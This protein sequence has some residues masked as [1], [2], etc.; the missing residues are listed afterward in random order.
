MQQR[1]RRL[2]AG[3]LRDVV[4][5]RGPD[6][7]RGDPGRAGRRPGRRRRCRSGPRS[8]TARRRARRSGRGRT[9]YRSPA[10]GA[11]AACPRAARPSVTT[12]ST[13]SSCER[14]MQLG[15]VRPPAH[16][17]L[18]AA[19]DDDVPGLTGQAAH[20]DPGRGPGDEPLPVGVQPDVGPVDL[21]VVVVLGVQL[22][23]LLRAP[24]VLEVLHRAGGRLTC[25]VPAFERRDRV[26]DRRARGARRARSSRT[27]TRRRGVRAHN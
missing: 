16:A 22:S 3:R 23:D 4:G 13:P 14:A 12:S 5:D 19:D 26:R 1:Q 20:G 6:G 9:T 24:D 15:A 17:G 21:E 8:G 25:V 11:C 10:P 18:D 2:G 7:H 27:S